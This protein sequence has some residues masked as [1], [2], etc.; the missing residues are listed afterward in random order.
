M[1]NWVT[2][3]LTNTDVGQVAQ[4]G[5]GVATVFAGAKVPYIKGVTTSLWTTWENYPK[6]VFNTPNGP[7]EFALIG[8]RYYSQHAVARMQPSGQR[9]STGLP[10]GQVYNTGTQGMEPGILNTD[11]RKMLRGRSISPANVESIIKN[12]TPTK[13][14]N[15]NWNYVSGDITVILSP[16]KKRVVTVIN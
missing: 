12:S 2:T 6:K 3:M 4:N 15:G 1:L 16:D 7:Q 8:N 13:Q 14:K 9:Y 10:E 5:V 11:G